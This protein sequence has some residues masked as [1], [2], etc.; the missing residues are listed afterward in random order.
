MIALPKRAALNGS[1]RLTHVLASI[2]IPTPAT[3]PQSGIQTAT[4]QLDPYVTL[5]YDV[6]KQV[7]VLKLGS[8]NIE[9]Y[10]RSPAPDALEAGGSSIRFGPYSDVPA[11][12]AATATV[13]FENPKPFHEIEQLDR[14]FAVGLT[15]PLLQPLVSVREKYRIANR[16]AGACRAPH[17]G[18]CCNR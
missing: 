14:S 3:L 11:G 13:V 10:D 5:P 4:L 8:S 12:T 9:S 16:G 18:R 2:V 1:L 17:C 6:Q 7:T 15:Y